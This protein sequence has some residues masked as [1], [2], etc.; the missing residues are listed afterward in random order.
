M[1]VLAS[2]VVLALVML[3]A[4]AFAQS[5]DAQSIADAAR[6]SREQKK[7]AAKSSKVVTDDDISPSQLKPGQEGLDVGA[8]P[9]L[10]TE[11][12]SPSAVAAAEAADNA[13]A[14]P[15]PAEAANPANDR[16]LA[17]LKA[18]LVQ[19]Q[20]ELDLAQ[21]EFALDQDTHL[22]TPDYEHDSAGKAKVNADKQKIDEKQ[23]AVDRLK[24]RVAALQELK[25]RA[26]S[27]APAAT[28]PENPPVPPKS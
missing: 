8:S 14:T 22:S 12:P 20:K 23:Q 15:G 10:E 16:E 3:P 1:F 9:K 7:N 2:W 11:P 18:Q 21:R 4:A 19:A 26:K 28:T 17:E 5:S 13:A 27:A 24:T 6:R 25:A